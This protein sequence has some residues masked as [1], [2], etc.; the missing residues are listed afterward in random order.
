MHTIYL[1]SQSCMTTGFFKSSIACLLCN[2]FH[3]WQ[4]WSRPL[5][6]I[7]EKAILPADIKNW[8]QQQRSDF[9][10]LWMC[11]VYSSLALVW[12]LLRTKTHDEQQRAWSVNPSKPSH[13]A[14]NGAILKDG[15]VAQHVP[16]Y[17]VEVFGLFYWY[18]ITLSTSYKVNTYGSVFKVASLTTNEERWWC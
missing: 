16:N 4:C 17:D 5:S 12:L 10:M 15:W 1:F 8:Q 6:E 2:P 3:G 18:S 11:C 13:C 9:N 14:R 7:N